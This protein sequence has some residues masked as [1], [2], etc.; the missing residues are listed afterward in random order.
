MA[1]IIY[2]NIFLEKMYGAKYEQAQK[3]LDG[4]DSTEFQKKSVKFAKI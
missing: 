3:T 4:T 2:T 1:F